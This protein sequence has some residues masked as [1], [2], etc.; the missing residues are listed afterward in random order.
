MRSRVPRFVNRNRTPGVR[1]GFGCGWRGRSRGS[2]G[3]PRRPARTRVRGCITIAPRVDARDPPAGPAGDRARRRGRRAAARSQGVGGARLPRRWPERPV[4]RAQ[5]AELIFG[6]ADDPLGALRWTL[7]QLRRALGA[8]DTLRG[9][10]LELGPARRRGGRRARARRPATP[11]PALARGELLEGSTRR[12]ARSSTRGCW[13][14]AGGSRACARRCCATRRCDALAAGRPLD[15]AALASR[16]LALERVRR[17]RARAARALPRARRRGRRGARPRRRLR[18]AVPPRARARARSAACAGRPTSTPTTARRPSAIARPPSA[19]SRRGARRWTPARSSPASRACARRARRRARVGDPAL[20]ARALAALGSRSC[21]PSA[22]ATRRAP[23]CCTRRS[24]SPRPPAIA[25]SPAR[26][27]ASSASSRCRPGAACRRGAGCS[28]AGRLA[29][30]TTT[31]GPPCSAC[32]AWPCPTGRT[33]SRRSRCSASRS[34]I[35]RRCG[36][37]RARRRGRW[38]SSAARCCCATSC[39]ARSRRST[40]RSRSCTREGW[41]A[42]QPFPEALRAE[43]AL[44]QDDADRAA[45]AARARL[46]ARLPPRRPL[47]GGDGRAR[48]AGC[49]TRRPASGAPA[50]AWLRDATARAVR[51]ADRYV[52]VH[53]YCLDALAGVAIAD[54]APDARE[55]VDQLERS[56]RARTCASSSCAPRCTGRALGDP[57]GARVRPAAG[58]GDRQRG[59]A[60]RAGRRRLSPVSAR[61]GGGPVS[62]RGAMT[63]PPA[64]RTI[65]GSHVETPPP[66][67]RTEHA[68]PAEAPHPSCRLARDDQH[69]RR[70]RDGDVHAC[71]IRSGP[72][73]PAAPR[74]P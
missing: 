28:R 63:A 5:L 64:A 41:V 15:G 69:R 50:L 44:R 9:D 51:V 46:R 16:A 18:R 54:A 22:A 19:S 33:T 37:D 2:A 6:D 61:T 71:A 70:D 23:P 36:D 73:R 35:A 59:A 4:A 21:T 13:W 27:A 24:R 10:P 20:L 60:R 26:C 49:C 1:T 57:G 31:S 11:D 25:R 32:A 14:S 38:R 53:G 48:P 47:L 52:W 29:E 55:R 17:E 56:P 42:F 34:A 66:T 68:R 3:R 30:S 45:A 67:Q 72:T 65:V 40:T 7:A 8:P 58:R 43:V 62:T 12:R 39:R 74:R